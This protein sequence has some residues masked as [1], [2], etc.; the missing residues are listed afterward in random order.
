MLASELLRRLL[1]DGNGLDVAA[2]GIVLVNGMAVVPGKATGIDYL[3]A[4]GTE[5]A[6]NF[7]LSAGRSLVSLTCMNIIDTITGTATSG[8]LNVSLGNANGPAAAP[9]ANAILNVNIAA[10]TLNAA[11]GN[12]P[13]RFAFSSNTGPLPVM[14]TLP[15]AFR[16]NANPTGLTVLQ[17]RSFLLA[18]YA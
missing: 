18:I 9:K 11:V 13:Y 12:T 15:M 5:Y 1:P 2:Q 4:P 7:P 6:M 8:T 10:A 16:V 3:A 14:T 17:G